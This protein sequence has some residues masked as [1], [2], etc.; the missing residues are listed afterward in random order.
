MYPFND[1]NQRIDAYLFVLFLHK[2]GI[3]YKA[4]GEP[5][6]NDNALASLALLVATTAP[7]QKDIIVKLVMNI[8]VEE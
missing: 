2:N 4:N 8:L 1:G 7:Q 3:L 6:I 5:K